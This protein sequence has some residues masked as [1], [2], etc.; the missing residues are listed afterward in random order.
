M[1]VRSRLD[2]PTSP[3]YDPSSSSPSATLDKDLRQAFWV[4][5]HYVMAGVD[6]D[7][8]LDSAER[9]DAGVLRFH[10]KGSVAGGQY[11][12][13][14]DVLG[15]RAAVHGFAWDAGRFLVQP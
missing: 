13:A 11:P 3:S 8:S 15:K 10:G 9:S 14:W 12:R 2:A 7:H 4:A 6:G 5:D 1:L